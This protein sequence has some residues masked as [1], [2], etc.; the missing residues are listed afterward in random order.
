[1]LPEQF[2]SES[3]PRRTD[4][5]AIDAVEGD[6]I[7]RG[8][9]FASGETLPQL[10]LHYSTLGT[11]RRD[12]HGRVDNAVLIL[13]G[14]TVSGRTFL[15][16]RFAGVLFGRG[17][18]LDAEKFFVILPDA[19]GHGK[20]SR[21]SDGLRARFPRYD[22]VDMVAAQHLLL[23]QELGVNHLRLV[24]GTSMGGMQTFMWGQM[25]PL[26]MDALMPLACLP[27]QIAGRNRLWRGLIMDAVRADPDWMQG[28]YERQ[29]MMALR[30]A[31]GVLLFVSGAPILMQLEL[32]S[33]EAADRFLQSYLESELGSMDANDLLY[34]ID[35]SRNYDPSRDLEK[36]AA[37]L[38]HINSSDDFVNPPDLGIAERE[39]KRIRNARFVLLPSSVR[40]HGHGTHTWA[41]LWRDYL[42]ELLEASRA[43]SVG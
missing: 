41:A 36:I 13:H 17:Q 28:E 32:S 30:A 43:R 19:I 20:S 35:A 9:H 42:A 1:M 26:F 22:Y 29:P 33:R 37:P 18:P 31:A 27:V 3:M 38:L 2:P 5:A 39:I 11:A 34:Q 23:T 12:V 14:T 4:D 25:H 40:T 24:L 6:Y 7:I 21:P 15:E 16:E 10:R 8:F